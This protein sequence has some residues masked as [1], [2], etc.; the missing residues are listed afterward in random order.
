MRTALALALNVLLGFSPLAAAGYP[1]DLEPSEGFFA[2][3]RP[4]DPYHAALRKA[5][6]GEHEYRKCQLVALPAFGREWA[7]YVVREK[8]TPARLFFRGL[9]KNLGYEMIDRISDGG[10]KTTYSTGSDAQQAAL[11]RIRVD[12]DRSEAPLREGTADLLETVWSRMLARTRY[13]TRHLIGLDGVT[14]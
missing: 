8:G 11:A 2:G 13:P 1:Q 10:R 3:W 7:V 6:V 14:Y 5:L 9:Q 12:P 4:P